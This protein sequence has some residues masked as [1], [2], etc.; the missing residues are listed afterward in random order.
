MTRN[1][2]AEKLAEQT[3]LLPSLGRFSMVSETKFRNYWKSKKSKDTHIKL[4]MS[5]SHK[6]A[7]IQRVKID[8][9][10]KVLTIYKRNNILTV[11]GKLDRRR[12][13]PTVISVNGLKTC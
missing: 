9:P 7:R 2:H 4:Q 11:I 13:K 5:L 10:M 1:I 8:L 3:F 6:T 12:K